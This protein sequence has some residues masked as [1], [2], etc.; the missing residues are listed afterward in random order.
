MECVA[1]IPARGGSKRIPRKN[2]VP[3]AGKPLLAWTIEAAL[4]AWAIDHVFVSTE[5]EEIA[6][7]ARQY[8]AEAIP[9]P[10]DLA[11]DTTSTEP[12]LLHAL[13]WLWRVCG[14][15]PDAVSLL[16]CTSPLR[17]TDIIERAVETLQDTGCDAVVG[18]HPVIDYFFCGEVHDGRFVTG[19]DPHNRPRTQEIAPR[20]RENGSI[21]VTRTDHLRRTGCRMGGDMRAVMMSP[22]EGLDIDD[23]SDL[24]VARAHLE[25][26]AVSAAAPVGPAMTLHHGLRY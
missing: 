24:A 4:D 2:I 8:G 11:Q 10:A 12:V 18:V 14:M 26:P 25:G 17:G 16:Q 13:D 5:D 7:V 23:L 6:R 9:R 3:L 20:Y 15:S 22:V 19:Y 1:I 21:Y